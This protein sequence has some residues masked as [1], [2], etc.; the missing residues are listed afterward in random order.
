VLQLQ[1]TGS[2]RVTVLAGS[3]DVF[4]VEVTNQDNSAEKVTYWIAKDTRSAVKIVAA[5]PQMG[6][7]TLTA[8]LQ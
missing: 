4:R 7:A 6:G 2:E 8:E 5:M 1:V 3:F